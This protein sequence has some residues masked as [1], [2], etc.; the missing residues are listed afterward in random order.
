MPNPS[1]CWAASHSTSPS[2]WRC[3]SW[4]TARRSPSSP[5]SSSGATVAA[6]VGLLDDRW[7]LKARF[8][9]IGQIGAGLLLV[10]AGVTIQ[11][12]GSP[13]IDGVLTVLW[14]VIITNAFN[15]MDNMDGVAGGVG[16][17]GAGWYLLLAVDNNQLLVAPLAAAVLGACLGFLV[18]NFAPATIFMGDGGSLFLGFVL[19]ALAIKLRFPGR[20]TSLT[21]MIPV[22]VSA[23]LLFDLGLVTV[24]RARRRVNP[25][26][27][28][29]RDH[30][31]HRLTAY[32]L[33]QRKAALSIYAFA[34]LSGALAFVISRSGSVV[35]MSILAASFAAGLWA[36]WRLEFVPRPADINSRVVS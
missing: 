7:D 34:V 14:V 36:L 1:H 19:A 10:G 15:F 9:L 18:Y 31:S 32:G 4:A 8:K 33:T 30:L 29:G 12:V 5:E 24:S 27:T 23:P 17:I 20:P 3:F 35:G 6:A 13:L 2:L 11:L 28:A 26:T 22:F 16:A 25:F 21:W